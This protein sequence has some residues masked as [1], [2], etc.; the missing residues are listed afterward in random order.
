MPKRNGRQGLEILNFENFW[1]VTRQNLPSWTPS[2]GKNCLVAITPKNYGL[3]PSAFKHKFLADQ[4]VRRAVG[5]ARARAGVA[6]DVPHA[7]ARLVGLPIARRV[8]AANRH[9][10]TRLGG[11]QSPMTA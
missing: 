3:L 6:Q 10:V 4:S 11:A 9:G 5:P 7:P 8:L 1:T 2:L